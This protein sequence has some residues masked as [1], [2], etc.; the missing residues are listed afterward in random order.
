MKYV[1]W[2]LGAFA[3]CAGFG[4]GVTLLIHRKKKMTKTGKILSTVLF[5]ILFATAV[6]LGYL[7]IYSHAE[8]AAKEAMKGNDTV[9][10]TKIRGGYF[11]D[12]PSEDTALVFYPGAKVEETAYAPLLIKIAESGAD[13]FLAEMP[14]RMAIFKTDAAG[15]L[16]KDTSY[17]HLC[18]AGHSMGGMIAANYVNSHPDTFEG[19]IFL[20]SYPV[21]EIPE[22]MKVVSIYGTE[23]H[24][25]NRKAYEEGKAYWSGKELIIEGGNHAQFGNYGKQS[26]DG[27]ALIGTDEQQSQTVSEILSFLKSK[28][29]VR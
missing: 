17:E 23:D 13:C 9:K 22:A 26:G 11:F 28:P 8:D 5:S 19:I 15:D 7:G 16:L 10:V 21:K 14:F 18:I 1:L 3:L 12:G 24:C 29:P 4:Y 6:T 2:T 20:A 25:L 27:E